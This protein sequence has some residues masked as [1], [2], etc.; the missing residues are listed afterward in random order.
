[1]GGEIRFSDLQVEADRQRIA[2]L[3]HEIEM[4]MTFC[5][6]AETGFRMGDREAAMRSLSDARKGYDTA[7]RFLNDPRYATHI[8][9]QDYQELTMGMAA[10]RQRL[11]RLG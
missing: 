7:M 9:Q 5:D 4:C 10:V 11:D 6:V 8:S 2:F 1:M 3:K